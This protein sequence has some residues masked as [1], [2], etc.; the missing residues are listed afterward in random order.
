[1]P[2]SLLLLSRAFTVTQP[3]GKGKG[4]AEYDSLKDTLSALPKEVIDEIALSSPADGYTSCGWTNL[5]IILA[6]MLAAF[7]PTDSNTRPNANSSLIPLVHILQ[8]R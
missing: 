6:P 3:L 2:S 5:L 4:E 1:M 8:L 7:L